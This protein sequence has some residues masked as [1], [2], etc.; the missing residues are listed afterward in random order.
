MHRLTVL[1]ISGLMLASCSGGIIGD[2]APQW[3]GGFPKDFRLALAPR[4]TMLGGR[5][6]RPRPIAIRRTILPRQKPTLLGSRG[7]PKRAGQNSR[8]GKLMNVLLSHPCPHCGH[9]HTMT[10]RWFSVIGKLSMRLLRSRP[11]LEACQLVTGKTLHAV[12]LAK[13]GQAAG[14]RALPC[15]PSRCRPCG[16]AFATGRK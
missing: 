2:Y 11:I 1:I 5:N 3:A 14:H 7:C 10:R 16:S 13:T 6:R 8:A 12:G 15:P 9:N 4:N